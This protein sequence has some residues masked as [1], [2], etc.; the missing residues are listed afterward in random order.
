MRI[1]ESMGE[2]EGKPASCASLAGMN[3]VNA[4]VMSALAGWPGGVER[5]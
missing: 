3:A 1:E 4:K 2:A 5:G